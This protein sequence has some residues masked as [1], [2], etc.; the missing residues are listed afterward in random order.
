MVE[1]ETRAHR[2]LGFC[3]LHCTY[4]KSCPHEENSDIPRSG[5][6]GLSP[7]PIQEHG[8]KI[9]LP[10][11]PSGIPFPPFQGGFANTNI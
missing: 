9:T 1:T 5:K 8:C 7:L 11:F 2:V 3:F 6:K 4:Q 10:K